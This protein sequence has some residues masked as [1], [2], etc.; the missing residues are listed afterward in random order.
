M[1][2]VSRGVGAKGAF[3]AGGKGGQARMGGREQGK[4]VWREA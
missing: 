4:E 1:G 3:L 2:E